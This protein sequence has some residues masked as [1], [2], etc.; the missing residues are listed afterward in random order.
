MQLRWLVWVGLFTACGHV[1]TSSPD[2]A[3]PEMRTVTIAINGSGTGTISSS[4]AGIDCGTDCSA[5]FS[6]GTQLTLTATPAPGS[7]FMGWGDGSCTGTGDC[8]V[9]VGEDISIAPTF[10]LA[11]LIVVTI[12]G[13]GVGDVASAPAG[14]ACPGDCSEQYGPGETVTLTATPG[15][16]SQFAGWTNG[17]CTG[18]MPC[19]V[20]TDA[21]AAITATFN[22][23]KYALTITKGGTGT[24]TV[25]SAPAGISCGATCAFN[26]NSGA[27]VTLTPAPATGSTFTSWSGA[28]TGTGACTVSMTAAKAVTANFTLT[29]HALSVTK[30]GTGT[31]TVT[32]SPAGISCGATCMF[33]FN[34]NT[35]VTL[36]HTAASGSTFTGWAGACTGT[37]A[38]VVSMT[39]MRAVTATFTKNVTPLS[40]TSVTTA[41]AC[42]NGALP[43]IALTGLNA[44]QCRDQ[45]ET[46]MAQAGM[47]NGCWVLAANLTC[48]CR[49]G[50]LE[51]GGT[52]PG[53]VCN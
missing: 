13:N 11:H 51:L 15:T 14:I 39:A 47:A 16:E 45:C 32:S 28:C 20:T 12:A 5:E 25:T 6:E 8:V 29:Q 43:Q 40:C 2:A 49:D 53:G 26:F 30:N 9:T 3:E 1:A 48:Y 50:S 34:Y 18:T 23:K 42:T 36:G 46:K 19:T 44:T 52:S 33:N 24:G 17:G 22:L 37:G 7:T 41:K 35:S 27:M 38:C 31:G 10:A 4:P 21:A